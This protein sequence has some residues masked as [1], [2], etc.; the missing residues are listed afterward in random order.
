MSLGELIP[1]V[2]SE[3]QTTVCD[4][5]DYRARCGQNFASHDIS[6]LPAN[7][8][9]LPITFA[10]LNTELCDSVSMG[11]MFYGGGGGA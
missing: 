7:R 2:S 1:K 9:H 10:T 8:E 6:E 5:K 3:S 4:S 11:N